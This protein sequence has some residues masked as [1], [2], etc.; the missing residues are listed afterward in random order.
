MQSI[1][2]V[3][4]FWSRRAEDVRLKAEGL[5]DCNARDR[6]LEIAA[7]CERIARI[8]RDADPKARAAPPR[9]TGGNR[10]RHA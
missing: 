9:L 3:A 10:E 8:A 7:R 2:E 4:R 6:L 1:G 5:P